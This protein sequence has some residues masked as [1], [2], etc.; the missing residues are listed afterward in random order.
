MRAATISILCCIVPIAVLSQSR[1]AVS[2]TVLDPHKAG[3]FGARVTLS[4][5]GGPEAASTTAD[6]NGAFQF[7]AVVPGNY[8][9]RV[10]REDSNSQ[11]LACAWA[12]KRR[13]R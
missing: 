6:E 10:E 3:V 2:G 4:K 11:L 5:V 1:V 7:E 8:D 9:V 12:P 13:D